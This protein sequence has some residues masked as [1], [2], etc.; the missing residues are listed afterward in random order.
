MEFNIQ[1][2][3]KKLPDC[4]GAYIHKDRAGQIIYVGKAIS[5]KRR[6]RQYFQS[7][8]YQP[9][10]VRKMVE[11]IEKFEYVKCANEVDALILECRLIK[12]YHPKYNILLRDD[13]TYPYIKVNIQDDY[14]AIVKTRKLLNDG[15]RYFG[16]YPFVSTVNMVVELLNS[17]Y[18]LKRCR[19]NDFQTGSFPCLNY[20]IGR[21]DGM[22][23]K[24]IDKED[25]NSRVAKALAFLDG[26][27]SEI[28][29]MLSAKM[30]DSSD[31]MDYEQAAAYRDYIE[32][33]KEMQGMLRDPK[34]YHDP[35]LIALSRK[36]K[37]V[38]IKNGLVNIFG[39]ELAEN[40]SRIESYDISHIGG[41]DAV[42]AMVVY[43][44][45]YPEKN[46]YRRYKLHQ[47]NNDYASMQ[48][49][50]L[51]RL[52]N[53]E[54][55]PDLMLMDG[56]EAQVNAALEILKELN[57]LQIPVAGLV[58]DDKHRTNSLLYMNETVK[59]KDYPEL[60]AYFGQIQ[61]EVHRFAINYHHN[62]HG[63][64]MLKSS[65]DAVPGI[66]EKR[67][68]ELLKSFGSID[69]IKSATIEELVLVPSM[70]KQAAENIKE[71]LK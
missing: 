14:P 63:K 6:V 1:E 37:E 69:A 70:T 35:N 45:T 26:D 61:E 44:N 16:P 66:G 11:H 17:N 52:Q 2:E 8:K 7:P 24:E 53:G 67:K 34:K 23:I 58:K 25:Y 42:G 33:I 19:S 31:K 48:E 32:A 27:D 65:L 30:Q 68:I 29:A 64:N 55:L 15:A 57:L 71:Y 12:Q 36:Q 13:K 22:C 54:D 9:E 38:G 50:L 62:L 21:C 47:G 46:S 59:L 5:L 20:H 56:G 18:R 41:V 28:I 51:R 40:M 43:R 10:K 3:L 60:Y 4:P 39:K 49:L